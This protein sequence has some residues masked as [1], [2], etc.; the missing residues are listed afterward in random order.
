MGDKDSSLTRA[1]PV[2]E[3]LLRQDSINATWLPRLVALAEA[4]AEVSV[5][6]AAD[7]RILEICYGDK[8]KEQGPG[9]KKLSP[10]RSLLEWLVENFEP[11]ADVKWDDS[12]ETDAKR[13]SLAAR[14]TDTIAEALSL[15]EAK[16]TK[17]AWYIL[18]G[19]TQPDIYVETPS[20]VLVVEG[21]R[22]EAGPTTSTKWMKT[23]HQ[24]LRHMDCAWEIC[25]ARQ[26]IGLMIVE[27]DSQ[28]RLAEAWQNYPNQ[29]LSDSV[30]RN[31][32]PHRSEDDRRAIAACFAGITT[33]QKVCGEFGIP[34]GV[35]PE[36][37]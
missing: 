37:V 4:G 32:L 8:A 7:L 36:T 9:E 14:D 18:E 27:D 3:E 21:K 12:A 22:T 34:E 19:E 15:L 20:L 5:D 31:S 24:M 28:G 30:L 35:L 10:P 11:P 16:P 1:V 6:S 29:L 13:R 17:T 2:M 25:G 26:L 33:W 23:R